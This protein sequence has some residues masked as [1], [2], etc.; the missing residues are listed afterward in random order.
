MV[1]AGNVSR[2]QTRM[3]AAAAS[4]LLA[5]SL[6]A[7]GGGSGGGKG[8]SGSGSKNVTWWG[9]APGKQLADTYL[10]A[11]KKTHPDIKVTYKEIPYTDYVNAL[12][13]GL[14]SKSGPDVY[15]LQPGEITDR[16]GTLA[17]DLTSRAEKSLGNDWHSQIIGGSY[18]QFNRENKQLA[19]PV[20]LSASGLMWYDKTLFDKYSLQPPTNAAELQKVCD[21]LNRNKVV[22]MTQGGKDSWANLDFYM[23]LAADLAPGAFYEAVEGKK[24]WTDPGLV[25][26]FAKW[27]DMFDQGVFAKGTMGLATYPDTSTAFASGKAG[28]TLLGTWQATFMD[29][30]AQKTAQQGKYVPYVLLPAAFPDVNGD[31]Q[32]P[33]T[34]GGPDYG[35]SINKS[36]DAQ[37]AAWTFVQWLSATKQGQSLIAAEKFVPALKDV[38]LDDSGLVNPSL[39]K[40]A[41]SKVVDFMQNSKGYREIPYA[42]LK[43][44]LGDALAAVAVGQQS[45]QQ[46]A[47]SVQQVSTSIKR[48]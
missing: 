41:L 4:V 23:T 11:F 22:C 34:F 38:P 43:T 28:M 44:A 30:A 26:A 40:P 12:R 17:A 19:M 47:Q 2:R 33:Q 27:K 32:A 24:S 25:A 46:A 45:P 42:D 15:A 6:S 14:R 3:F 5:V 10:A 1:G 29:A 21:T 7:C 13:L 48:G 9:W 39:Q 18:T 37:D 35:L 31:G 16:F 36:S 8:T 20:Q